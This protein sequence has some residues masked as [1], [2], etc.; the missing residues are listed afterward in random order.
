[1][2]IPTVKAVSPFKLLMPIL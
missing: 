2:S 1:M